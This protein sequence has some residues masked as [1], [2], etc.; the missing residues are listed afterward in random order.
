MCTIESITTRIYLN[1]T[2]HLVGIVVFF[3]FFFIIPGSLCNCKGAPFGNSRFHSVEIRCGTC[4]GK[5]RHPR[6]SN[7]LIYNAKHIRTPES[8]CSEAANTLESKK[9]DVKF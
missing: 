6:E 1:D 5:Y 8:I 7:N 3:L 2:L 4:Q 9:L